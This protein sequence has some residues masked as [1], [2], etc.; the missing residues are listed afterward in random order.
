MSNYLAAATVTRALQGIVQQAVAV[1]A[2]GVTVFTRRPERVT[3]PTQEAASVNVFLLQVL[4]NSAWRNED[5]PTRSADGVLRQPPRLAV[6]LLF[7]LTF[8]GDDAT[9][10][11]QRML[12][13][14]LAAMHAQARLSPDAIAAAVVSG[15]ADG[16]LA[17]A[18]LADQVES[19]NFS[20]QPVSLEELS[21]IW[22]V[23]LQVPYSLSALY[24]ASAVLLDSGLVAAAVPLVASDGFQAGVE[25]AV[26]VS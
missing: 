15:G 10:V 24:L 7:L 17:R 26:P 5:L 21:K 22:A 6:D 2:P 20:L 12:G 18:D 25:P 13:A 3:D 16:P 9:L 14:V 23:L 11:P 19:I 8:H 4:P 1:V